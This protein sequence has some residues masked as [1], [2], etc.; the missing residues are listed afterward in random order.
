[1][2]LRVIAGVM[3]L[4]LTTG[5]A[6]KP[7]SDP[8]SKPA[9]PQAGAVTKYEATAKTANVVQK[10]GSKIRCEEEPVT[11]SRLRKNKVCMTED[12]WNN[13]SERARANWDEARSPMTGRGPDPRQENGPTP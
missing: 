11:N 13:R 3:F 5:C 7:T 12:A 6:M 2:K 9:A 10:D 8:A 4:A 1:M